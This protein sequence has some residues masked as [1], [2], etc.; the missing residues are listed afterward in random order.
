[1]WKITTMVIS[2]S[3]LALPEPY[4]QQ[5]M[6][7]TTTVNESPQ[8]KFVTAAKTVPLKVMK[9]SIYQVFF[10]VLTSKDWSNLRNPYRCIKHIL[11]ILAKHCNGQLKILPHDNNDSTAKEICLWSVFPA[12]QEQAKAY[13]L[14]VQM[15][16]Q[17]FGKRA[18]QNFYAEF[19]V[20]CSSSVCWMKNKTAVANKLA[21]QQYWVTWQA[22]GPT[23]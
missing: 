1:M 2:T 4:N 13:I 22:D 19:R 10:P 16:H 5:Q 20:S 3:L 23:V 17:S 21:R 18:G 15:T 11:A 14:N 8:A 7:T 9:M 6:A 12:D